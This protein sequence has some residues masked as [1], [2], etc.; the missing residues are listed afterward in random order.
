MLTEALFITGILRWTEQPEEEGPEN[1]HW[2][3][4][5]NST[6]FPGYGNLHQLTPERPPSH[7]LK[8]HARP[9]LGPEVSTQ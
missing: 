6:A 7:G 8:A 5:E 2:C 4:M 1:K 9:A 3:P